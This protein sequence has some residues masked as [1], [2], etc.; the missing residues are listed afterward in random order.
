MALSHSPQIVRDGLVLYLDAAN[1]KSYPGSGTTWFDLSGNANNVTLFNGVGYDSVTKSFLFDGVNDYARTV[2]TIDFSGTNKVTAIFLLQVQDYPSTGGGFKVLYELSANF[3][4][5]VNAFIASYADTSASQDYQIFSS[6]RGNNGY[7]LALYSKTIL[8]DLNWHNFASIHDTS[9]ASKEN[10][11]YNNS[12]IGLEL[13]NPVSGLGNNNTNN[14][15]SGQ[16]LFLGARG[17]TIGFSNIKVAS[18]M[19]YNRRLT[20][21]ELKTNFNA[22]RGRYGI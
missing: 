9:E 5:V 1:I 22:T 15:A 14:F 8:N 4:S 17:G 21:Q 11:I 20:E 12:I 10:L 19:F 18:I 3:N 6:N 2:N 16:H 7:N 13:Q